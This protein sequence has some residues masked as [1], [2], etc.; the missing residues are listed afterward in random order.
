MNAERRRLP[1]ASAALPVQPAARVRWSPRRQQY[2]ARRPADTDR[3][4]GIFLH[5]K[6]NRYTAGCVSAPIRQ[7]RWLVRWPDPRLNPTI[8]MGPRSWVTRRF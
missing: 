2:V 1:A 6:E 8:V 3:G 5:V 7:V 4:G